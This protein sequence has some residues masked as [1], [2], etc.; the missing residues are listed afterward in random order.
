MILGCHNPR[1]SREAIHDIADRVRDR[2][3]RRAVRQ[4]AA[5]HS[6][7]SLR[8]AGPAPGAFEVRM[9]VRLPG[10]AH[11]FVHLEAVAGAA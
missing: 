1:H 3:F 4:R 10:E 5:P 9:N 6:P 7:W 11:A 2:R 8:Y